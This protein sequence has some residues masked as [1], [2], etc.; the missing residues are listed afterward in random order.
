MI[1]PYVS[2]KMKILEIDETDN[3]INIYYVDDLLDE[4]VERIEYLT[5]KPITLKEK[6]TEDEFVEKFKEKYNDVS[7]GVETPKKKETP[8][9]PPRERNKK[10]PE[11]TTDLSQKETIDF[12]E[13]IQKISTEDLVKEIR[14]RS[15]EQDAKGRIVIDNKGEINFSLSKI[16]WPSGAY[17]VTIHADKD[18]T[19][20]YIEEQREAQE[21]K[22]KPNE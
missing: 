6:I 3:N 20:K 18:I 12:N 13:L 19:D 5:N 10:K 22:E 17:E 2:K 8:K 14:R 15:L 4:Q 16:D 9:R 7:T 11:P 1:P 21:K